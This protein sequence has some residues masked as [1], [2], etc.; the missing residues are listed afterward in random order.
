MARIDH[1]GHGHPNTPD[2]RRRCRAARAAMDNS[3]RILADRLDAQAA[4]DRAMREHMIKVT[5][6]AKVDAIMRAQEIHCTECGRT[7]EGDDDQGYSGCCNEP[8]T[9]NCRPY[10]NGGHCHHA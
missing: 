7:P 9:S 8:L 4:A 1:T 5:S 2:A 10:A 6:Q 3:A